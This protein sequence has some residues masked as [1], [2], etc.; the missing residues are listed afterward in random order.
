MSGPVLS[1]KQVARADVRVVGN[2]ASQLGK[3]ASH[4]H[5][6]PPFFVITSDLFAA[7]RA[8]PRVRDLERRLASDG[9]DESLSWELR[10][11]VER[12]GMPTEAWIPIGDARRSLA[13]TRVAVRSSGIA[14]DQARTS[15]AGQLDTVLDVRDDEELARAIRVVWSSVYAPRAVAYRRLHGMRADDVDLAVI[16]QAQ[17]AANVS[18]VLFTVDPSDAAVLAISATRGLGAD[19]VAG[20]IDGDV[21]RVD[22]ET[23][24]IEGEL[25]EAAVLSKLDVVRL[26]TLGLRLEHEIGAPQDVEWAIADGR[27]FLLQ[28]RP[29]TTL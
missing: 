27:L 11:L 16:V 14:E 18:G 9:T 12:V 13:S 19:L 3:L 17:V 4:G 26:A 10:T 5:A 28:S 7:I 20:R 1:M 29:V 25:G 8:D 21:Y 6:V 22:R 2:K 23:H 15:L 24:A